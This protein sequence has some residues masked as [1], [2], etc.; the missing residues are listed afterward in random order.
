MAFGETLDFAETLGE[1]QGGIGLFH[2]Q[3][4]EC[5][6]SELLFDHERL[7]EKFEASREKL[8][9][10]LE[11]VALG[12]VHLERF[13]DDGELQVDLNVLPAGVAVR[14]DAGKQPVVVTAMPDL[15]L[16]IGG[17]R[18]LLVEPERMK[19]REAAVGDVEHE[20]EVFQFLAAN[21]LRFATRRRAGGGGCWRWRGSRLVVLIRDVGIAR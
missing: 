8:V 20:L 14:D 5:R 2:G 12:H 13:V 4:E 18:T 6:S 16:V 9:L 3:A 10:H 1:C 11:K 7:F 17:Q 15:V 21:E 19:F